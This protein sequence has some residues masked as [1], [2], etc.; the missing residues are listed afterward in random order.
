MPL[1]VTDEGYGFW[2]DEVWVNYNG[3]VQ[4]A[5]EDLLTVYGIARGSKSYETQIGGER[6]VP[7]IDARYIVE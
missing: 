5:E 7:K 1:S 2:T 3:P 4:G 6:Y